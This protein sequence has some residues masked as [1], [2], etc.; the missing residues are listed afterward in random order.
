[1]AQMHALLP[2]KLR[3]LLNRA[4]LIGILE[5][6]LFMI[7]HDR[8]AVRSMPLEFQKQYEMRAHVTLSSSKNHVMSTSLE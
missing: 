6:Y 7:I 8:D 4:Y 1:M 3:A 2:S 5:R